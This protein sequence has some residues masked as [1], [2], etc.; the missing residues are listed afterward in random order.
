M[1]RVLGIRGRGIL[2]AI[3]NSYFCRLFTKRLHMRYLVKH[4]LGTYRVPGLVLGAAFTETLSA[5]NN[6]SRGAHA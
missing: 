6:W 4:F 5:S 1:C 3:V 2:P